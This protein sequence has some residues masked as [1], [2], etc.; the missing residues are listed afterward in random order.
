MN[1]VEQ[2][3]KY[4]E[5]LDA[6]II[7]QEEFEEKKK[8]LLNSTEVLYKTREDVDEISTVPNKKINT[9]FIKIAA[10]AISIIV[11]LILYPFYYVCNV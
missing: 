6:N 1:T 11:I 7:S 10:I 8:E 2:L 5:L 9:K 4:K 3:K